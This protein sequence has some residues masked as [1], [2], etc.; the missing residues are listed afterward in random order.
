MEISTQYPA[1]ELS[2]CTSPMDTAYGELGWRAY[3][4]W[5]TSSAAQTIVGRWSKT[6]GRLSQPKL[7][8]AMTAFPRRPSRLRRW[9]FW[10]LNVVQE[11]TK[12][13]QEPFAKDKTLNGQIWQPVSK[14]S[15]SLSLCRLL[16]IYRYHYRPVSL[17]FVTPFISLTAKVIWKGWKL[18]DTAYLNEN[19]MLFPVRGLLSL[20]DKPL[21]RIHDLNS[22]FPFSWTPCI[23]Q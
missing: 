7:E 12:C 1:R 2:M 17:Y 5:E 4:P 10:T 11:W 6:V 16:M 13:K 9:P 8:R 18:C 20:R 14:K 22:G 3:E 23:N 15:H 21:R 19:C